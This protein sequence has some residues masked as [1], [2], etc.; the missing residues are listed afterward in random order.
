MADS[1]I[2]SRSNK[3]CYWSLRGNFVCHVCGAPCGVPWPSSLLRVVRTPQPR[4]WLSWTGISSHALTSPSR[5]PSL[6]R[7]ATV[8]MNSTCGMLSKYPLRSASTASVYPASNSACTCYPGRTSQ[9]S[10]RRSAFASPAREPGDGGS[11]NLADGPGRGGGQPPPPRPI[12]SGDGIDLREL[13]PV[14]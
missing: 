14:P 12:R 3:R 6:T 9:S 13:S 10:R 7:R 5:V 1:C 8:F 4:P 2:V 11:R